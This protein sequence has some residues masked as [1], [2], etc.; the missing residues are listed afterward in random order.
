MRGALESPLDPR[1]G[2]DGAVAEPVVVQRVDAVGEDHDLAPDD[3]PRAEGEVEE[4]L[5]VEADA[6]Q[7]P[8]LGVSFDRKDF[9][10]LSFGARAV[11]WRQ[12]M[13]FANGIYALNDDGLRNGTVIPTAGV[14]GTF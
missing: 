2:D 3:G 6:E 10:D 13:V 14:E 7:R 4:V 12:I 8:L 9:F 1:G 11:V 5:A